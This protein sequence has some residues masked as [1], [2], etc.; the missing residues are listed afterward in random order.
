MIVDASP[1]LV[2]EALY[3]VS[4]PDIHTNK[5]I[6]YTVHNNMKYNLDGH[7]NDIDTVFHGCGLQ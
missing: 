6:H 3:G 4:V 7:T 1:M 2:T 5:S